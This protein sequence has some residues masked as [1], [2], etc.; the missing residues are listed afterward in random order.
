MSRSDDINDRCKSIFTVKN[1]GIKGIFH[2]T[3]KSHN[4]LEI[5]DKLV[6]FRDSTYLLEWEQHRPVKV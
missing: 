5:T 3:E 4:K 2:L 1:A 6:C